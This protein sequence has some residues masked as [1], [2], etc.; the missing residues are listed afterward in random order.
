MH[1]FIV[2]SLAAEHARDLRRTAKRHRDA[3]V[4][5]DRRLRGRRAVRGDRAVRLLPAGLRLHMS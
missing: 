5:R 4:A 3:C 2:Q 1:P